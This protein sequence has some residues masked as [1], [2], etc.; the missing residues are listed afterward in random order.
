M[1]IFY[2]IMMHFGLIIHILLTIHMFKIVIRNI[3]HH[4]YK[5]MLDYIICKIYNNI[6]Y[7]KKKLLKDK[8]IFK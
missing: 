2:Y 3:S 6:K 1:I 8:T 4:N 5:L 7:S